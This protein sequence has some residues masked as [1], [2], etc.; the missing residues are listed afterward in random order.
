QHRKL[1]AL[2]YEVAG[3]A[4]VREEGDGRASAGQQEMV[5]PLELAL[6]QLGQVG[7]P[8]H[9]GQTGAAGEPGR[10]RLAEQL[11]M[12]FSRDA[13]GGTQAALLQRGSAEQNAGALAATQ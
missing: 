7:E 10:K 9:R 13:R 8:L 5:Q 6:G 1:A 3:F 12:A 4:W 11:R 2:G